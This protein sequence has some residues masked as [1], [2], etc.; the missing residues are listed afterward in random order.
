V[1]VHLAVN[2]FHALDAATETNQSF[3]LLCEQ[4]S[5]SC[6]TM[7]VLW[8]PVVRNDTQRQNCMVKRRLLVGTITAHILQLP[9]EV[10]VSL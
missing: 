4:L 1:S 3:I 10:A 6:L 8:D 7:P 2:S 9:H 5:C